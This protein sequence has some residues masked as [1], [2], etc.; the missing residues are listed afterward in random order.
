[1]FKFFKKTKNEDLSASEK[2]K[3]VQA[4]ID[5]KLYDTVKATE[6]CHFEVPDNALVL[7]SGYF[8]IL[9]VTQKG[10][11]FVQQFGKLYAVGETFAKGILEKYPGKYIEVFEE[12]EE[13]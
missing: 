7:K 3:P 4:I 10:N 5:G 1:M 2:R 9:F 11:F 8:A 13:A 6:L 12:I